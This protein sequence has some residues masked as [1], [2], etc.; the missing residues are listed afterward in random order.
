MSEPLIQF[1]TTAT[2][3]TDLEYFF[4]MTQSQVDTI[5]EEY[6]SL[7]AYVRD[8]VDGGDFS[9]REGFCNGGW[10]WGEVHPVDEEDL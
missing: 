5:E 10:I 8:T 7:D 1:R 2:M 4:E 9:E 3:E 6:G